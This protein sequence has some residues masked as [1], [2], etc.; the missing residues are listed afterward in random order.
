MAAIAKATF[1]CPSCHEPID[2]NLRLDETA[3][4]G[5]GELVLA[6]DRRTVTDHIA[7]A[8]PHNDHD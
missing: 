3:T 4:P 6:V 8:R 7:R 5:P 1:V 2:L